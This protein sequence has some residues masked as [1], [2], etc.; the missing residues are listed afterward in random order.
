MEKLSNQSA[1]VEFLDAEKTPDLT[2]QFRDTM[3]SYMSFYSPP[4]K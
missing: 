1:L 3:L 2:S 4:N